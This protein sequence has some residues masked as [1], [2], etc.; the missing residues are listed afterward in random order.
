MLQKHNP[1]DE[2]YQF[3]AVNFH[4][5]SFYEEVQKMNIEKP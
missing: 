4:Q 3:L 5:D 2:I 1:E